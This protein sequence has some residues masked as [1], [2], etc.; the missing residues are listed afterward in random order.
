MASKSIGL[1]NIVFGADLRGFERAMKKAQKSMKK[2]GAGA[3]RVGAN[4][5]R[6]ITMPVVGLGAVAIKTFADFEQAMLKVQAI[7]GATGQDFEDLKNKAKE[8]GA[9]TMFT[10]SQVAELQLNLSKLGLTP[11]EINK[12]TESILNLAQATDSDLAQSATVA[13]S[14]MKG[15]GLE[16]KDMNRIA[17][18]MADSFS[19]TALDM[20]KFQVAMATVAPVANQAGASLEETTAVLGTLVNRGVD[21]S[22]AGTALRNVYLELANKGMT[23]KEAMDKIQNS[24]NPLSDAMQLFG[25]RGA[26]VATIIANNRQE[27]SGLTD[28]FIDSTG[29]AKDMAAIMDSGVGGA[30]RKLKSQAEGVAIE[31]GGALIPLFQKLLNGV[32]NLLG[33]WSGLDDS[34]KNAIITMGLLAAALGPAISLLGGI[35]TAMAA[36]VSPVGL[37]VA[38]ILGIVVAFGYVRENWEAFKER[39]GDWSW[40]KNAVIQLLQW[41]VEYNPMSILLD[42][43]NDVLSFFGR[44]T[45]PSPFEKVV[46]DLEQFKVKTKE[47]KN[48]FGSFT[49]AMKN[50]GK[51]VLALFGLIGEGIGVGGGGTSTEDEE[52]NL[53]I[54]GQTEQAFETYAEFLASLE[55]PT[56]ETVKTLEEKWAEFFSGWGESL[57]KV[58]EQLGATLSQGGE[59]F[60][61]FGEKAKTSIRGTIKALIGEG[62]AAAIANALKT[63]AIVPWMIPVVAGAA[64]G[65]ANTAF[66]SLIPKFAQGGLVTGPTMGLIGEG[67]GTSAFNPEVISPLDKLMSMMGGGK[68]TVSGRIQGDDIVLISDK[69]TISRERFI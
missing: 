67:S 45:I 28:D 6:N 61:E 20:E 63:T 40:W 54:I 30:L 18:V 25:K 49:D 68:V 13:A 17:D 43:F 27:I 69:A 33:W 2:F 37:A 32:K 35:A 23:W 12:S 31:L 26:T 64:A 42:G 59:S 14:T 55:E 60:K 52:S 57:G 1:L 9:S 5:T 65:L 22:S 41:F 38:A 50:Q 16:A 8:L 48:E 53:G 47:Y 44:E 24:T 66:S 51:E 58:T 3:K 15:F 36:I 19:S 7:S 4:M 62:V 29:E 56:A 21:A 10:A 11:D 46:E 39:L 34:V